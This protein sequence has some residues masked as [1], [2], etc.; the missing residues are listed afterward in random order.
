ML[1]NYGKNV[2]YSLFNFIFKK[3][4]STLD[5]KLK[6]LNKLIRIEILWTKIVHPVYLFIF[7]NLYKRY[8]VAFVLF[9]PCGPKNKAARRI[10]RLN[11]SY[12]LMG[13]TDIFIIKPYKE[14]KLIYSMYYRKSY[15]SILKL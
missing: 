3:K 7:Y 12:S 5:I 8:D 4:M 10:N 15:S 14:R 2:D 9:Q 11:L 6:N 13:H 1:R